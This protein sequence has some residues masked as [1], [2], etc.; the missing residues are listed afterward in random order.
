MTVFLQFGL[1][2]STKVNIY[3][4]TVNFRVLNV[5]KQQLFV[6]FTIVIVITCTVYCKGH[7]VEI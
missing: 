1:F 3:T 7:E 2:C 4:F 5:N 6:N